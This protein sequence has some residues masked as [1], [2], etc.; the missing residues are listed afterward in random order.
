MAGSIVMMSLYVA[1]TS[2]EAWEYFLNINLIN[3][4]QYHKAF[5]TLKCTG[6]HAD[7]MNFDIT[8][9]LLT[10]WCWDKIAAIFADSIF[11]C[12]LLNENV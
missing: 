2:R 6:L 9:R 12:I 4:V 5:I 7:N 3:L 1:A 8:E 10:H 11:K